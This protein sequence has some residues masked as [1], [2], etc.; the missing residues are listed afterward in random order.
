MKE[1]TILIP[2]KFIFGIVCL[3][4]AFGSSPLNIVLFGLNIN[5][6]SI[7]IVAGVMLAVYYFPS[8]DKT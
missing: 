5:I 3:F 2:Y 1:T 4:C 6:N 7:A 8:K